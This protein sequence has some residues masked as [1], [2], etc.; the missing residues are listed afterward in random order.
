MSSVFTKIMNEELPGHFVWEDE[1]CIAILSINPIQTGHTLVIPREEIDH[2]LDVPP[3]LAAQLFLV[4]QNIGHAQKAVF[5][6]PRVGLI[7]AGEE[8]PHTHLHVIPMFSI[9]DLNFANAQ[10]SVP[11][12]DLAATAQQLSAELL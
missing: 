5:N 1:D 8:V 4:A 12:E 7:I 9:D 2:W 6:P 3:D 11:P 10:A